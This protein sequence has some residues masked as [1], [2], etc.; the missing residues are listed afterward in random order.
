MPGSD[1]ASF[2]HVFENVADDGDGFAELLFGDDQRRGEAD[3][4]T[5]GRLGQ[6]ALFGHL[7]ADVPCLDAILR[8]GDDGVEQAFAADGLEVRRL[9]LGNF[10]AEDLAQISGLLG[11][12]LVADDFEGG[13]GDFGGQRE[14]A[15]R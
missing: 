6:E 14:P 5:V 13:D 4:V 10:L 7:Q 2:L 11:E 3:D 12:V 9:N 15:E 1:R 8:L